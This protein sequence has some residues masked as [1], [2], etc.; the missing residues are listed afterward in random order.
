MG[1]QVSCS[2]HAKVSKEDRLL[3]DAGRYPGHHPRSVQVERSRDHRREG[4]AG[5]YP[6]A[7]VDTAKVFG[8]QFYG[9]P[10]REECNDDLRAARKFEVSIREPALL[11]DRV[12]REYSRVTG[13]GNTEVYPR[14]RETGSNRG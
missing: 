10:E 1:V 3:G 9:I 11:G 7:A 4:D 12:L 5:S 13:K 14:A 2:I 6:S 8:I